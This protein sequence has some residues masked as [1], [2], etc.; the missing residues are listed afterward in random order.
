MTLSPV[1]RSLREGRFAGRSI[2]PGDTAQVE[3]K[4]SETVTHQSLRIPATV[5][6]GRG[7]GPTFY[8]TGAIHGDEVNGVA[9]VRRL[10]DG[11]ESRLDRGILVA[12]PV[13]N[14]FGFESDD[15]Y[16]P[17]RRDLNRHFPGDPKGNMAAR[18]AHKL[19]KTVVLSSDAG[20]DL[21]TAAEGNANLCHI[22][23][24]ASR[25]EV[26]EL[27]KAFGA[28]VMVDQEGPRGSLRRAATE[29][30]VPSVLYE[31]GEPGRFQRHVVEIGH[32]GILRV[33][34]HLGM[35]ERP[36]RRPKIQV[37][38]RNAEWVRSDHGGI[39]E[40]RIEPGDLVRTGQELGTI[41]DP[42]G[43]HVDHV[44]ASTSGVVLGIATTPLVHPGMALVH[45]GGLEKTFQR[46]QAYVAAGGD[47]GH[48]H[49][50]R[51]ASRR[52]RVDLG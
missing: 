6:R 41:F 23:G 32:E 15:R 18:I 44:V 14:R 4:V 16:L 42:Y 25:P 31:A 40:L 29:A 26:K 2:A 39:L 1:G 30:G 10:L 11:L 50:G 36:T 47:L 35:V 34:A 24:D 9:I 51:A 7:L 8:V 5:M 43:R 3:L 37:L 33:L 52:A 21:H 38:V 27:M 48:I 20:I 46:A 22:R 17:D 28:P 13:V 45:I 49:W 19:W 12:I